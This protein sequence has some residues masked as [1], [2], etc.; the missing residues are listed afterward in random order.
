MTGSSAVPPAVVDM[1][2]TVN[3]SGSV[4]P[5]LTRREKISTSPPGVVRLPD[6][7]ELIAFGVVGHRRV[8]CLIGVGLAVV[9]DGDPH[10]L[11]R[12]H[13]IAVHHLSEDLDLPRGVGSRGRK[14]RIGEQVPVG[15]GAVAHHRLQAGVRAGDVTQPVYRALRRADSVEQPSVDV[16]LGRSG[17]VNSLPHDEELV[18]QRV[19]RNAGIGRA[20]RGVS[21]GTD[22]RQALREPD[23]IA[24][25]P[26]RPR[27]QRPAP[28]SAQV[29]APAGGV[30][31]QLTR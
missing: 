14:S 16:D 22:L 23:S 19:V 11:A 3:P 24:P 12:A 7:P 2:A 31:P 10:R 13:S 25:A 27:C 28:L 17:G 18:L 20:E 9:G 5:E 29:Q 15:H 26:A 8:A 21:V 6:D 4:R 1:G 30:L